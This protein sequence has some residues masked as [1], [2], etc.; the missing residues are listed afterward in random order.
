MSF[1]LL[2]FD[3]AIPL[4]VFGCAMSESKHRSPLVQKL[5]TSYFPAQVIHPGLLSLTTELDSLFCTHDSRSSEYCY[6]SET[7]TSKQGNV[8]YYLG[9]CN[10]ISTE[11]KKHAVFDVS[12]VS[13]YSFGSFNHSPSQ[14][15]VEFCMGSPTRSSE[16]VAMRR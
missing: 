15:D 6:V 1:K 9:K 12:A 16:S 5:I 14:S 10:T 8:C 11:S 13:L 3:D 2:G 4:S 7:P